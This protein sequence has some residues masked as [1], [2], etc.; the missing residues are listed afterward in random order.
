MST[1]AAMA[2]AQV[3]RTRRRAFTLVEL[4]VVVGIIAVLI[5]LLMPTLNRARE[6]ARRIQ[7]LS[8]L[9]QLGTAVMMY[10]QEFKGRFPGAW[11]WH[12][13][14]T[15]PGGTFEGP[16]LKYH[17]NG[18]VPVLYTCPSDDPL[19]HRGSYP[20]TYTGNWHVFWFSGGGFSVERITQIKRSSEKIMIIDESSETVDDNV[21]APENW[22][23]DRQNMLSNRHDQQRERARES[24]P[25]ETLKR[26]KGNV[27]FADGHA[28][29]VPRKLAMS[30]DNVDPFKP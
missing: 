30:P 14:P 21:W 28:D 26:G 1:E 3:V 8:N 20:Y 12:P 22:F 27:V 10:T 13:R 6:S 17:N 19:S 23:G 5:A 4:L 7:C 11:D 24:N 18:G 16:L 29:F 9:R 15:G 25:E 2:L